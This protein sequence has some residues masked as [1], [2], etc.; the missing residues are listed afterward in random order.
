MDDIQAPLHTGV[1]ESLTHDS[2]IENIVT[3]AWPPRNLNPNARGHWSGIARS[4]RSARYAA[5]ILARQ[6]FGIEPGFTAPLDV[7]VTFCPPDNR[8]RDADNMLSSCKAFFDGIADAIRV[9]DRH[10]RLTIQRGEV[11]KDG[12]VIVKIGGNP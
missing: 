2:N 5:M 4:K 8:H 12:A 3:L 11:V 10:W 1:A 9:D 6:A 7:H